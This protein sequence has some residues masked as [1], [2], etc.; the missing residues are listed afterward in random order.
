MI[1]GGTLFKC[2]HRKFESAADL[3]A[4]AWNGREVERLD[5][6]SDRIVIGRQWGLKV[7]V[8]GKGDQAH[9]VVFQ[10]G[11][12]VLRGQ[13]GP[14]DAVRHD[15]VCQHRTGGVDGDDDISARLLLHDLVLAPARPG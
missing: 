1:P 2:L 14:G 8:S 3:T 15:I 9:T 7:G 12:H 10:R 11:Q 5:G 13:L 6:L 4:A